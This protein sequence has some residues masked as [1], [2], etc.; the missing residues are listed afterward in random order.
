MNCCRNE[1]LLKVVTSTSYTHK[2][3]PENWCFLKILSPVSIL[4]SKDF[5]LKKVPLLA[6]LDSHL[7]AFADAMFAIEESKNIS[8]WC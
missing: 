3:C 2:V 8:P 7:L 1:M 5:V 4:L 6:P